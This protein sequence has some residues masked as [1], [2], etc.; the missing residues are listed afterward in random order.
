MIKSK[1]FVLALV[2]FSFGL[3][4]LTAC[5]SNLA[6]EKEERGGGGIA[7]NKYSVQG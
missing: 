5:K 2:L 1:T 4:G 7:W 6:D 3:I